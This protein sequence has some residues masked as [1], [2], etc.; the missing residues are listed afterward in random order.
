MKGEIVMYNIKMQAEES[1]LNLLR[2]V[3]EKGQ[4]VNSRAG[5]VRRQTGGMLRFPLSDSAGNVVIPLLTTRKLF[6]RGILEELL[7]FLRGDTNSKHLEQ[8][9]INIWK[10]NSSE[11][12]LKKRGLPYKEGDIGPGY[13]FQWRHWNGDYTTKSGGIDQITDVISRLNSGQGDR[14]LIVSVWNPEQIEQMALPPCHLLFQFHDV[15]VGTSGKN[16]S[17]GKNRLDC[18][19][20]MRS[21]DLPLGVPFNIA[22]YGILTAII[23]KATNRVPGELVLMMGDVHIYENQVPA[24]KEWLTRKPESTFPVLEIQDFESIDDLTFSHFNVKN[25]TPQDSIKIPMSI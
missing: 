11:E 17:A 14:R 7:W 12:F 5:L 24:V 19:F 2:D 15:P 10:G 13:G 23:A 21:A 16:S 3:L 22:S 4:P 6:W 20:Y 25:Y 8:L 9:G 1:Y 18:T